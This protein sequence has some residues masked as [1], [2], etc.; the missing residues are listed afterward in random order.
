MPKLIV[1][2]PVEALTLIPVPATALVTP[3]FDK[4]IDPAPLAT[5]IPVPADSAAAT[6]ALPVDPIKS[7]PF[8]GAAVVVRMPDAPLYKNELA[9]KPLTVKLE[10]IVTADGNEN[11]TLPVEALTVIWF[12]VPVADN[13][14]VFENVLPLNDNPVPAKYVPAP[15]N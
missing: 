14:P 1:T 4:V 6:G 3:V 5:L 12:V 7:C 9:V 13:T 10:A 2:A 15:E 8:V 11:V